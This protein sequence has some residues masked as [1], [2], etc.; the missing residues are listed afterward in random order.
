[1]LIC[2]VRTS[3]S[4]LEKEKYRLSLLLHPE[5]EKNQRFLKKYYLLRERIKQ[6]TDKLIARINSDWVMIHLKNLPGMNKVK[7][8]IKEICVRLGRMSTYDN[9]SYGNQIILIKFCAPNVKGNG[10]KSRYYS[11]FETLKFYL[12]LIQSNEGL[13]G[14]SQISFRIGQ[15]F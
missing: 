13:K 12:K 9:F 10:S 8:I 14:I 7:S 2:L 4:I 1:M 6:L 5:R 3:D 15:T 11:I